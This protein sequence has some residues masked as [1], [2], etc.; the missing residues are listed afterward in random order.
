M[1]V[2]SEAGSS[3]G[4][5]GSSGGRSAHSVTDTV[6]YSFILAGWIP[7]HFS[8]NLLTALPAN[9]LQLLVDSKNLIQSTSIM[10][11]SL[12]RMCVLQMIFWR[13]LVAIEFYYYGSQS[14]LWN[15]TFFKISSFVF[16][17]RKKRI[18]LWNNMR[19]SKLWQILVFLCSNHPFKFWI[20]M[21]CH[22]LVPFTL[23]KPLCNLIYIYIYIYI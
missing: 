22:H 1:C 20:I 17:W 19:A 15:P 12:D 3:R 7:A 5:Q 11:Y 9:R 21:F 8:L 14:T 2:F 23:F 18:K 10:T 6:E 16:N 4:R 13:M